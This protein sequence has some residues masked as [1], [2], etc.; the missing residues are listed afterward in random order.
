MSDRT[1]SE[2][3][4]MRR[5]SYYRANITSTPRSS[6]SVTPLTAILGSPDWRPS[7]EQVADL[8]ARAFRSGYEL[9]RDETREEL[10]ALNLDA[11]ARAYAQPEFRARAVAAGERQQSRRAAWDAAAQGPREGDHPCGAVPSW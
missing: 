2:G 8:I 5:T 6:E 11:I 7:R 1:V 3:S 9:G 4:G 10:I